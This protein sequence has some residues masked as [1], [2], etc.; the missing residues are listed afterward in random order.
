MTILT[1]LKK[2]WDS[3]TIFKLTIGLVLGAGLGYSYYY[4]IGCKTGT[5]AITGSPLNST[6][7]GAVMGLVLLYPGK[8]K[9]DQ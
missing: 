8:R 3:N 2:L 6:L 1:K 7:Y 4:F 9:V 5:C